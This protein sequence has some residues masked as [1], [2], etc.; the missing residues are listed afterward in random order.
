MKTTPS[1]SCF[2]LYHY[3]STGLTRFARLSGDVVSPPAESEGADVSIPVPL[4]RRPGED[5]I[6]KEGPRRGAEGPR[7][8][9]QA[10]GEARLGPH[11]SEHPRC[12]LEVGRGTYGVL[13]SPTNSLPSP[14]F[15][16]HI[17]SGEPCSL[18]SKTL[19]RVLR[20]PYLLSFFNRHWAK[21][22]SPYRFSCLPKLW[23]VAAF[24]T[25][26]IVVV[27]SDPNSSFCS[28]LRRKIPQIV[29]TKG[30]NPCKDWCGKITQ[31]D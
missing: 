5:D 25:S 23:M 24:S 16:D 2:G 14:P 19:H 10:L 29:R 6:L 30:T 18:D 13:M 20:T 7:G 28:L 21:L 26:F 9:H 12:D 4:A 8:A 22:D 3:R 27:H 1:A 17:W 31:P 15:A 11:T